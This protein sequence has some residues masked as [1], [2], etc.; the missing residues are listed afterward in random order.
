MTS[1]GTSSSGYYRNRNICR[2]IARE[3]TGLAVDRM[4]EAALWD[5]LDRQLSLLVTLVF[6]GDPSNPT[7]AR[8]AWEADAIRAELF[9]R[10]HQLDL[11]I[12][13]T[14]LGATRDGYETDA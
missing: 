8:A 12:T 6:E 13:F 3:G 7:I 5:R 2:K 14:Q 4:T 9:M 10:G 11:P 1:S